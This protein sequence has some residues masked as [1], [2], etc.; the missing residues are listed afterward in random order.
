[1]I[2]QSGG[3]VHGSFVGWTRLVGRRPPLEQRQPNAR[4]LSIVVVRGYE[5][6]SLDHFVILFHNTTRIFRLVHAG[7]TLLAAAAT[8]QRGGEG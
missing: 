2:F 1:M 5:S 3:V 6:S 7:G 4:V 8:I